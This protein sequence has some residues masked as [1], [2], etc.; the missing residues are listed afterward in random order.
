[1]VSYVFESVGYDPVNGNHFSTQ[2]FTHQAHES[3][4]A[5][6]VEN[7][8][9]LKSFGCEAQIFEFPAKKIS[10]LAAWSNNSVTE[11]DRVPPADILVFWY[12]VHRYV[13]RG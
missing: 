9:A 7:A 11:I 5:P 1:V 4:I 2:A 12:S 13:F 8:F 6:N 10:R 3:V